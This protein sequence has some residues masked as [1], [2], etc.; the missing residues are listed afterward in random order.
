MGKIEKE[1]KKRRP[2]RSR[3]QIQQVV[4]DAVSS[5]VKEKGFSNITIT[6]IAQKSEVDINAI[7]RCFGSL[8]GLLDGYVTLFDFWFR[9]N[10]EDSDRLQN[11]LIGYYRDSMIN[12]AD[13]LYN[14]REMQELL[15]WEICEENPTTKKLAL[16][17]EICNESSIKAANELFKDSGI[18]FDVISALLIAGIYYLILRRKRSPFFGVDFSTRK[19]KAK[20]LETI[21]QCVKIY[22]DVLEKSN[23]VHDI[24]RRMKGKGIDIN[25][26]VECTRLEKAFIEK[27]SPI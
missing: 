3:Q 17:R 25:T 2:R 9:N 1:E 6:A 21:K 5:L 13:T 11:D 12:L 16:N 22:F 20:L 4:L 10:L 19:G 27:L 18:N 23:E 26:I 24:A 15:I 14:R 8:E 7:L